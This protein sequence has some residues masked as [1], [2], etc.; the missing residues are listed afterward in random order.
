MATR[1]GPPPIVFIAAGLGVIGGLYYYGRDFINRSPNS[2]ILSTPSTSAPITTTADGTPLTLLG[3][4]FS[5]YSTFRNSKFLDTL[6]DRDIALSY[7]DEF[8]Q[9]TRAEQ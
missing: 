3:D 1:K 2:P 8:V 7:R 5:G 6:S 9:A 4:T